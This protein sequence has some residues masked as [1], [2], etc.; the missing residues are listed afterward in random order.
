MSSGRAK[1]EQRGNAKQAAARFR[2]SVTAAD[3]SSGEESS[4]AALSKDEIFDTLRNRRRR[5]AI[6]YL[7]RHGG[8]MS[9]SDLAT[10]VAADEHDVTPEELSAEQYKRVYTGL[11]Q[12]HLE[13]VDELGVVEFDTDENTVRLTPQASALDPFLDHEEATGRPRVKLGVAVVAAL[14]VT[15]GWVG[16]NLFG[17]GSSAVLAVFPVGALLGIALLGF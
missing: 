11:Y 13:R 7:R 8:E 5:T 1:R 10:H 6:R 16:M 2:R 9:V 12:C 15:A 14:L 17:I 4:S 3:R